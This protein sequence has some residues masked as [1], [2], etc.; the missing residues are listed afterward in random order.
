MVVIDMTS[1][2][3]AALPLQG[4]RKNTIMILLKPK[5]WTKIERCKA[6]FS[7]V[8]YRAC[9]SALFSPAVLFRRFYAD[10]SC[11]YA[12]GACL[13]LKAKV[14]LCFLLCFCFMSLGEDKPPNVSCHMAGENLCMASFTKDWPLSFVNKL[15]VEK[16]TISRGFP[17]R[18]FFIRPQ[19]N[20][21]LALSVN[22][23]SC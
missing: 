12:F 18:S 17:F 6:K 23:W 21:C 13:F 9:I 22:E 10:F 4:V 16:V 11:S 19:S 5:I 14:C 7:H 15:T 1:E 2:I 3:E 8:T 20:H